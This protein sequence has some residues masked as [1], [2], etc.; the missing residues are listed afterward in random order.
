MSN[1]ILMQGIS[2]SGKST[3]IKNTFPNGKVF[4]ADIYFDINGGYS[5]DKLGEAHKYCYRGFV[6]EIMNQLSSNKKD[7]SEIIV[8]NTNTTLWEMY[9]YIQMAVSF[10]FDVRVIR[11][12]CDI[13]TAAKRNIHN[14]PLKTVQ[15]MFKRL[16]KPLKIW[17][18]SFEEVCTG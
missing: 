3:Y 14:V 15:D 18:C 2:G 13:E 8:D 4:S 12:V 5:K 9:P 16:Q 6:K 1:V 17:K 10:E 11:C 7:N